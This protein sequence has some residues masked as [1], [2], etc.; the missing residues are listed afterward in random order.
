MLL[1]KFLVSQNCFFT[2]ED[3]CSNRFRFYFNALHN[4]DKYL[5][6]IID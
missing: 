1:L 3:I 4:P 5:N 2:E 6:Q